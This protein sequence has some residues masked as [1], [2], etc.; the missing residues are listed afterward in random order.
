MESAVS[1]RG[2]SALDGAILS[3]ARRAGLSG[4]SLGQSVEHVV[5]GT[6]PPKV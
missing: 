3:R 5:A 1:K 4:H 2:L 6:Q